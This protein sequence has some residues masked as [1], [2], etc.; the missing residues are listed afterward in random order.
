MFFE[1]DWNVGHNLHVAYGARYF[2]ESNPTVTNS[3]T[4]RLGVLWSPSKHGTWTIHA[5]AGTFS[6]R[7]SRAYQA[8][9]LRADGI[10]RTIS[11]IYNPVFG[12][13]FAGATPIQ[14]VREAAPR[15]NNLTWGA[16]NIGGTWVLPGG[17]NLSLDYDVGRIWNYTRSQNINAPL[18]GSP[19]GAR[20]GAANL[21]VLQV[22][23]S[24]QGTVNAMFA[25]LE[26]HKLKWL[27]FFVGGVRVNLV[28]DT[29]DSEF[30]TPQ[31]TNSDVGEFAHRSGQNTWNLFGNGTLT[32]PGKVQVSSNFNAGGGR[33][34]NITTGF[35]NNG[36]GD[37]NDRPQYA[38]AGT[39]GAI[40]T[41][42]GLLVASGGT[43]VFPRNKGVLP[44][45]FYVDANVQR[46]FKLTHAAKAEH[47][48]T[49]TVNVRS[50]NVLN[51]M[52]VTTVGG[53]LG[54]PL[55]GVPFVADNGRRIEV[56][57]RYSF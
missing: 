42:Y 48:Q 3:I 38:A 20:P 8:E 23:N 53:V 28:D 40:A 15:L 7:F 47:Q 12:S 22:Q 49:L 14:S 31:T 39:P 29:D 6:G 41:Q 50:S 2:I 57:V 52:N 25:G 10:S 56:G 21:N 19:M 5:H 37:F 45:R 9:M 46:A 54:S 4:P 16:E 27:Q 55:F 34:Y 13:P 43:A 24:G 33:H 17:L 35:D 18:N 11:T 32:L 36:D 30:F 51:H 44:W 1:D 26:D